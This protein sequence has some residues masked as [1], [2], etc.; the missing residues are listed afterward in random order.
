MK[1]AASLAILFAVMLLAFAVIAEA[2][3]PK[4]VFP[5]GYL[6]SGNPTSE[7]PRA[8]GI[9]L[10]LRELGY[11]EG[12]NIAF[13]YRYAEGKV[14]R[15][16]GLAAELVRLKVDIIV[17]GGDPGIRAAKNATKTIPIVMMG[18][19]S[20]PVR[21]GLVESFARPGGNVT[22]ITI[23]SRE[24]GGKRLE[25]LKEAVPKLSRVAVLY[26]PATPGLHEVKELLPADARALQ[27]TIQHWEIRAVDDF[28]K[29]F[30]AL[31]KQLPDG[32]YNL[33]AGGVI[34]PNQKRIAG[35][36]LKSRLPSVSASEE[37][38]D[39]GG[40]MSYAADDADRYR[41]IAY[42]V[43][44]ILKGAKPADLPIEQATKFELV[45]NLKTAK[46]IGLTIPQRVLGR[47]DRVIK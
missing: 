17:V 47:A 46:Q 26:D 2:Q 33:G 42:Y 34:R 9:R 29:V 32:L 19:G 13:E 4:K 5:I 40:L 35:F 11:I 25:L 12:Q 3:Q 36:A 16:P 14:D 20:D 24:L 38:V 1:R 8:E 45:I 7:S 27:L 10:A 43:D 41:R 31:N 37:F 39:A 18:Q 28:E 22:G 30:A 6:S 15:L 23:L 21:A 44:K